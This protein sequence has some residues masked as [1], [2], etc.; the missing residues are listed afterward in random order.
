MGNHIVCILGPQASIEACFVSTSKEN[1]PFLWLSRWLQDIPPVVGVD[2]SSGLLRDLGSGFLDGLLDGLR[3]NRSLWD[4]GLD[5]VEPA[6]DLI[7]KGILL[8]LGSNQGWKNRD[9]RGE[10]HFGDEDGNRR[11][12]GQEEDIKQSNNHPNREGINTEYRIE[13][14]TRQHKNQRTCEGRNGY[15]LAGSLMRLAGRKVAMLKGASTC[16]R[17]LLYWRVMTVITNT[18]ASEKFPCWTNYHR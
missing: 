5:L 11:D 3:G 18:H 1:K 8:V 10:T 15:V 16:C 2:M 9:Q 14:T 7:G 6:L 17:V 12:S 13:E 4:E